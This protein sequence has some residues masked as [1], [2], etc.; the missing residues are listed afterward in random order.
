MIDS[1]FLSVHESSLAVRSST[2]TP[3]KTNV[4]KEAKELHDC[5]RDGAVGDEEAQCTH[6]P[7][8]LGR[9]EIDWEKTAVMSGSAFAHHV[10]A[11]LK[12][13]GYSQ[14]IMRNLFRMSREILERRRPIIILL[15][16]TSGT[17]KS[18]L[19]SLLAE[20]L[21]LSTVVTTDFIRH[22]LRGKTSVDDN[23]ALFESTYNAWRA[24]SR[25]DR[26]SSSNAP[27]P[28]TLSAEKSMPNPACAST[29]AST[30]DIPSPTKGSRQRVL[31]GYMAQCKPVLEKLD[32]VI[33]NNVK[34]RVSCIVEGVHLHMEYVAEL[35]KRHTCVIPF[36]VYISNSSKHKERFAI[37]S[38][39]MTLDPKV[40]KY[41]QSFSSI[42]RIQKKLTTGADRF[43][44]P[45]IDN[46]NVDR[47]IASIHS[48][49][50]RCLEHISH[51]HLLFD[52]EREQAVIMHQELQSQ[53]DY[54]WSS[55]PMKKLLKV[56]PQKRE[57]FRR[58]FGWGTETY[59]DEEEEHGAVQDPSYSG[60]GS[61]GPRINLEYG[62]GCDVDDVKNTHQEVIPVDTVSEGVEV[63]RDAL[64][65]GIPGP[66]SPVH[67]SRRTKSQTLC[68]CGTDE[69]Y[70][71]RLCPVCTE[72]FR[73]DRSANALERNHH[74]D[75][76]EGAEETEEEEYDEE[77]EFHAHGA[78]NLDGGA[79][80]DDDVASSHA[81]RNLHSLLSP[82]PHHDDEDDNLSA[83][84]A[85]FVSNKLG[86]TRDQRS[87]LGEFDDGAESF[88]TM[89]R[90]S[91]VDGVS[92]IVP[93]LYDES[94]LSQP[95]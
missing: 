79:Y 13:E 61:P 64:S 45:Q 33:N 37:R 42:R 36:L 30:A 76:D 77:D 2:S 81:S 26:I 41:V 63:E 50:L 7:L 15:A 38:K 69:S 19:S 56:K 83:A 16:G 6:L 82:T 8:L 57:L 25:S 73:V 91:D 68:L 89:G 29:P 40:N 32:C 17:G 72:T 39:Y 94:T 22:H 86:N 27:L 49:I 23:P 60:H 9:I 59:N 12:K 85:V 84:S 21:G 47:S 35:M 87:P 3:N 67:K 48:I 95:L 80:D 88:T 55:K 65:V 46:T 14:G 78:D 93:S 90:E 53:H 62:A 31:A 28:S 18:T 1:V 52:E 66:T 24:L 10:R 75:D 5:G 43:L 51:D 70:T 71:K 34:N 58:L 54:A 11:V 74:L 20:R 4:A 92:T 44:I